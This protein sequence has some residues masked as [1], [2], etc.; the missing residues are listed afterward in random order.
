MKKK[1]TSPKVETHPDYEELVQLIKDGVAPVKISEMLA[2]RYPEDKSKWIKY[3]YLYRY[4][5][6]K[7]PELAEMKKR[8]SRIV[9]VIE[10]EDNG[11]IS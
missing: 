1:K 6:E 3:Q 2:E 11:Q 8:K 4:R 9:P 7:Y 5:R 10:G